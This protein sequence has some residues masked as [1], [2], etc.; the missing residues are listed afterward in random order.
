MCV[1][2]SFK[3]WF[4][5]LFNENCSSSQD[6]NVYSSDYIDMVDNISE[7]DEEDHVSMYMSYT[8]TYTLHI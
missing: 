1:F 4:C 2:I 3:F 7:E 6:N 8:C 5:T